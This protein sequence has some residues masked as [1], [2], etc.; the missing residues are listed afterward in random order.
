MGVPFVPYSKT[1]INNRVV[2]AKLEYTN[3]EEQ[4]KNYTNN[5]TMDNGWCWEIPLW[6]GLSVGYVHS[7]KFT[8]EEQIEE[9][10]VKRYGVS[11]SRVV[12]FKTGRREKAW[13]KNVTSVGLSFGFIEPL[14]A[15]GLASIITNIFRLLEVFSANHKINSFDRELFNSSVINELDGQKT[16]IDIHYS[17]AQR[18]DTDYWYHVTNEIEY[19]WDFGNCKRSVD[20]TIGDR[21][22]S[23]KKLNGGVP[24]ILVGNEYTPMSS[25]FV[26][27]LGDKKYYED[28]LNDWIEYDSKSN[29]TV[30]DQPTTYQYLKD[31]VY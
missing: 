8:T 10:F 29:Q 6:D 24:F 5:V 19:D 17:S 13:V 3:K 18:S 1:L 26:K 22:Y 14:E 15:T 20:A 11:P 30:L 4:L 21:D 23:D 7:L 16:F 9:E 12:D 27:S 25:G 28:A 31:N 2:T